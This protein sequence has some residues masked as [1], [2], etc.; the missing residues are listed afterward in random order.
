MKPKTAAFRGK[1]FRFRLFTLL[2]CL[3]VIGFAA[4][5]DKSVAK[6]TLSILPFAALNGL[7]QGE[8]RSLQD[9]I[10]SYLD[11]LKVFTLMEKSADKA[12]QANGGPVEPAA[13]FSLRG[14]VSKPQGL[15][16]LSLELLKRGSAD[17]R[18]Y[19]DN[20]DS[21]N[22]LLIR[23]REFVHAFLEKAAPGSA[24]VA[25][26]QTATS[27]SAAPSLVK[28]YRASVALQDIIGVWQGDK[29]LSTVRLQSDGSGIASLSGTAMR[30]KV[31]VVGG[32]ILVDQDQPNAPEFYMGPTIGF[33]LAKLIAKDARPMRWV[34]QLS[35]D[36]MTL[37]G[38]KETTLVDILDYKI[39]K[40]DNSYSRE[41][42]WT[43]SR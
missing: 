41:A 4:A 5:A 15:Y 31:R 6:P 3:L 20:F 17:V 40:L 27:A 19:S 2:L 23:Y 16:V 8:V 30:L 39:R 10:V 38:I 32:T 13:D 12:S 33:S 34:F 9:L 35:L 26:Q 24:L 29:G 28:G 18:M 36:G 21:L 7:S 43:K 37:S 25:P 11:S 14:T 42:A 1:R 22:S